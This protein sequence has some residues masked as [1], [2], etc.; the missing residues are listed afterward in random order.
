MVCYADVMLEKE[1]SGLEIMEVG[2]LSARTTQDMK[3]FVQ[4][5]RSPTS[6]KSCKHRIALVF[7]CQLVRSRSNVKILSWNTLANRLYIGRWAPVSCWNTKKGDRIFV[8]I[9]GLGSCSIIS[10]YHGWMNWHM[11]NSVGMWTRVKGARIGIWD[12]YTR[13]ELPINRPVISESSAGFP[14]QVITSL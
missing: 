7:M 10:Q 14:L 12:F 6:T 1:I 2:R 11:T 13:P 4:F 5:P 9:H 3:A 8:L